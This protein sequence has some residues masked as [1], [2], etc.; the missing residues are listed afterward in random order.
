MAFDYSGSFSGSFFGDITASNGVVSSSAQVIANL[1]AG[2]VSSSTQIQYNSVANRPQTITAFQRNSITANTNFRESTFP[3]I[4]GSI[5]TRLT[6]LEG[7]SDS[8]GSEQTLSFNDGT[9]ALSISSGNSVD[10][11]SLAGGGGSGGG[12]NITASIKGE[13]LSKVVR[14]FNFV[15]NAVT[16]SNVGNAVTITIN[17]GSGGGVPS[18]TISSSAQLPSGILSSSAQLPSGTIS[19]SAQLPSGLV[20][21]SNQILPITTS[22]IT[23]FPTEVSKS[24][25]SFG[26]GAGGGGSTDISA[27]NTFT[28][29]ANTS[30]TSLNTFTGSAISN[31]QT[32]SMSVATASFATGFTIF[33]GNRVISNTSL[34]AGV[35]NTNARNKWF[36]NSVC[37]K[38][39]F[40]KYSTFNHNE[41][42]YNR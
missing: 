29:S 40:P 30:I 17:T 3:T 25:A 38:N 12:T 28:G 35:Y 8:T 39:I 13:S 36:T 4:S 37:R 5:S 11:S 14:S 41:W 32:S 21:S 9:N 10:L 42:I 33:N 18:G 15:G 1:P 16:A 23:N 19:S 7:A 24:A 31:N 27:L 22:S 34:P 20:S 6:T 26:F 2:A